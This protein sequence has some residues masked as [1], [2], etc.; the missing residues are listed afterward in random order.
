MATSS[1]LTKTAAQ[2]YQSIRAIVD[3]LLIANHI[4]SLQYLCAILLLD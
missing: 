4:F 1:L 2:L 3:I